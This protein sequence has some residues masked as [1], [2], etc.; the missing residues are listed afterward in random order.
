MRVG[1]LRRLSMGVELRAGGQAHVRVWAPA[2]RS[3]DFVPAVGTPAAAQPLTRDTA[4]YF[5]GIVEGV[6]SRTRYW[7]RLDGDRLRPDPASRFQPD[8]P[9]GPSEIV[10]PSTF[11][12][13]DR[14][15]PGISPDGQVLYEMHVGT[16]TPEGT[17]RA[18]AEQLQELASL[19]VTVVEMMPIADFAGRFGWG[20]DGVNLY[21]PTRLYGSPDDLRAFIDRAHAN[22]IAVILDVV[23]NHFGPDGNYIAEFSPDY[24]TNKYRNDWGQPINFEGPAAVRDF[25]V[26]NAS[27][28]I[29]EYHFDGLR[30]DATQDIK[31]A[32]R[33]HII[34]AI[35]RSAREAAARRVYVV[36]ENEPQDARLLRP[37]SRGGFGIDAVWN[38]DYHHAAVVALTARREAYYQ[39]YQGTAQ[40]LVSCMKYGYLYQGQ[41]Y[42]WQK[43]RRGQAALDLPHS[44][45]VHYVENHDQV[46]NSGFGRR[47]HQLSAPGIYRAITA[48]T[49]LGPAT[50]M[51][52][53]GQEF[54]S[55]APFVYFVDHKAELQQPI[56]EGRRTFLAQFESLKNRAVDPYLLSPTDDASF[57]ACKL[58]FSERDTHAESYAF[59]R[60]LLALRRRDPVLSVPGR[61]YVDGA[62]LAANA[63]VLRYFG[64]EMGDRLLLVNLGCDLELSPAPEPLLAAPDGCRWRFVWSSDAPQYGGPGVPA[65]TPDAEWHAPGQSAVLFASERD[66]GEG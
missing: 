17:W 35:V 12:W 11:A 52:F 22:G 50:P 40:E 45:Y 42:S 3:V 56:R 23:Y 38:D 48:L 53:Q 9:H 25:F 10:D 49:L 24:F 63:F 20:Y 2:C 61:R 21:A 43:K 15:W 55:S 34:A 1:T 51:L 64:R 14:L 39:D 47:L 36:A 6:S 58:D 32:S 60:D 37:P 7:F 65:L 29:D 27:Y 31:D 44:A 62:V 59:H 33:E 54:D 41:W 13:T 5:S 18:A 16:F 57:R 28:W 26:E 30:L 19:G 8:G 46:A 4:G 66:M